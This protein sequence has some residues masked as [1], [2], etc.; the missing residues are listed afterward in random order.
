MLN[1]EILNNIV[2][3]R[4]VR[5]HMVTQRPSL[6]FMLPVCG[7]YRTDEA[8]VVP[9]VTQS[10]DELIP[11]FHWEVTAMTLSA[12]E[13]NIIWERHTNTQT[14]IETRWFSLLKDKTL[15][16]NCLANH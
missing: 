8:G 9:G 15:P 6:S 4:R 7:S 2:L 16:L 12:E 14:H 11:C 13:C 10:L 1:T 5:G 3:D